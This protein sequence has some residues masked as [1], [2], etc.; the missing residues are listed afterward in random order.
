[1]TRTGISAELCD[2]ILV[3][4]PA[5][6]VYARRL[7]RGSDEADDLVQETLTK[8]IASMAQFQIGTDLRRWIFTIMRNTFLTGAMKRSREGPGRA[9]CVSQLPVSLPIHDAYITGQQLL[10]IIDDLPDQYREIVRLVFVTGESYEGAAAIL[11]CQ[12][13]TVKS[14]I[15]RARRIIRETFEANSVSDL[16]STAS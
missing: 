11:G 15:N 6:R 5:L 2:D 16:L 12:M 10:Q 8:G 14:R 13:G 9:D 4:V 1:M 7:M 3:I